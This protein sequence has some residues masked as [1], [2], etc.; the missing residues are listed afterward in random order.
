MKRRTILVAVIP[1]A[2]IV[3]ALI[4][5]LTFFPRLPF[6]GPYSGRVLDAVTGKPIAGA[7]VLATWTIHDT[8]LPDGPSHESLHVQTITDAKGSFALK[9]PTR[10]GG[11]F[12]TDYVFIVRAPRHIEAVFIVDPNNTPL[13]AS[14]RNWP[15]ATTTIQTTLPKEMDIRLA[16]AEPVFRQALK[17]ADKLI[18]ETAAEKLKELEE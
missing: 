14:T 3:L 8:P 11:W 7:T 16:P 4:L 9:K 15:F 1:L 17:S 6:P 5:A 12:Q 18:R 2:I 13:P 10:R